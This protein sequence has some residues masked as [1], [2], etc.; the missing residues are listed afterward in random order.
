MVSIIAAN[1]TAAI[2]ADLQLQRVHNMRSALG[3][4][5]RH[6]A[7]RTYALV[8]PAAPLAGAECAHRRR[9]AE[10]V[11]KG[12]GAIACREGG[13]DDVAAGA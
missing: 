3:R 10:S 7:R 5:A 8:R 1:T 6:C 9:G 2:I 11:R 12:R 4:G 13:K